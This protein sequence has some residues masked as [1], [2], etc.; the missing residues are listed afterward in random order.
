[1]RQPR[2]VTPGTAAC[3][4]ER[5]AIW[6]ADAR[7]SRV[8]HGFPE[9]IKDPA[10]IAGLAAILRDIPAPWPPSESSSDEG[11]RQHKPRKWRRRVT[12]AVSAAS[13][14]PETKM[15]QSNTPRCLRIAISRSRRITLSLLYEP[16]HDAKTKRAQRCHD[17]L[18]EAT[19]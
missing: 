5:E 7:R 13:F 8:E 9:R 1:M 18:A 19:R 3:L 17:A 11:T 12:L 15:R 2:S 10:A 16:H 6:Q 14:V 4:Q